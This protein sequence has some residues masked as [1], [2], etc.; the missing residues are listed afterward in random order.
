MFARGEFELGAA[1][2][3]TVP[4]QALVLRDGFTYVFSVDANNRVQQ[5]KVT[6]GRR[7]GDRIEVIEGLPANQVLVATGAAFLADGDTVRVT[8]AEAAPAASASAKPAAPAARG[9]A[10]AMGSMGT[11][12]AATPA[13]AAKK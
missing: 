10:D 8:S 3:L 7:N 12:N 5:R 13:P 2:A 6:V 4:Q 1:N 9:T 11:A